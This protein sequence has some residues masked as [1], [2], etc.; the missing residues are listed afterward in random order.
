MASLLSTQ[1][2][3]ELRDKLFGAYS[4]LASEGV[5]SYS[6]GDQ[7]FTLRDID[8]LWRQIQKL[9]RQIFLADRTMGGRGRNR[10]DMRRFRG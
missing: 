9:E 8:Q 7:T 4:A 1:Q 5:S 3:V 2:L 6:L 10:I